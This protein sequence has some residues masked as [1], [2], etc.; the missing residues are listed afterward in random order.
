MDSEKLLRLAECRRIAGQR[1]QK[2]ASTK[3]LRGIRA[4][5]IEVVEANAALRAR[6]GDQP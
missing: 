3:S 6:A 2:I 4:A 5:A 1:Y